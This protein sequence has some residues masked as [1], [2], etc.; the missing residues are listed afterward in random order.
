MRCLGPFRSASALFTL[1]L[2]GGAAAACDAE[3]VFDD[4][5]GE[6]TQCALYEDQS[7]DGAA[8]LVTND[9]TETVYLASN[10][11]AFEIFPTIDRDGAIV[12]S[13]GVGCGQTC[14]DLQTEGLFDCAAACAAPTVIAV[15][16]GGSYPL[17]WSGIFVEDQPMPRAC[18]AVDVLDTCAQRVAA[19]DGDYTAS[20][21][22]YAELPCAG[23]PECGACTPNEDGYCVVD[24]FFDVPGEAR[25][26]RAAFSLPAPNVVILAASDG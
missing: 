4:D 13:R 8:F 22:V 15:V 5:G 16:P 18:Y 23:D 2:L 17:S 26:A 19:P 9:T 25:T 20:I 6:A 11:C 24:G 7:R 3:V 12:G 21:S 14:E 1:F 10:N